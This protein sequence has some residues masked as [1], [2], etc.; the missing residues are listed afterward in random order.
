MTG[1]VLKRSAQGFHH[2]MHAIRL[3]KRGEVELL[4]DAQRLVE[5]EAAAR[6]QR[7][8]GDGCA[9]V[10]EPV[11]HALDH[12]VPGQVRV[13]PETA[14]R[15]HRPHHLPRHRTGVEA[16]PTLRR[17]RAKG[18]GEAGLSHDE[19]LLGDFPV[20]KEHRGGP[21]VDLHDLLA[22]ACG[23]NVSAIHRE[24]FVGVAD[25]G[26]KQFVD[27]TRAIAAH[28][29]IKTRHQTWNAGS[30]RA[31]QRGSGI[32]LALGVEIHVA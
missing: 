18:P 11:G 22:P 14:G 21:R 17:N 23:A 27:R 19:P 15:T 13:G 8:G 16:V 4:E 5:R 29:M 2:Q 1:T 30:P 31:V 12:A 26:G 28:Q 20:L 10:G 9:A 24:P 3:G 25:R 7:R 32:R 6:R